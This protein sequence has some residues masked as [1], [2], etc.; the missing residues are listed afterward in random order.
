[1]MLNN[2]VN[3][4][5]KDLTQDFNIP[6]YLYRKDTNNTIP[7][8]NGTKFCVMYHTIGRCKRGQ[9]C[10]YEHT[11]PTKCGKGKEFNEYLKTMVASKHH[12]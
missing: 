12:R 4:E 3:R 9:S 11:C 8:H 7:S 1:M 2:N 6:A 5:W 10:A